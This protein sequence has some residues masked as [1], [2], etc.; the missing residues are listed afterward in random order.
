MDRTKAINNASFCFSVNM[1]KMLFEM[2]LLSEEEYNRILL[3]SA[4][5]YQNHKF[6]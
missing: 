3:I 2:D 4:Q 5:Y 1:L 6:N